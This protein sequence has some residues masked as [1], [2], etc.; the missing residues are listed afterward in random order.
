MSYVPAS[1]RRGPGLVGRGR[2]SPKAVQRWM[3]PWHMLGSPPSICLTCSVNKNAAGPTK[4]HLHRGLDIRDPAASDR[5]HIFPHATADKDACASVS[6]NNQR[7][8]SVRLLAWR[9]LPKKRRCVVSAITTKSAASNGDQRCLTAASLELILSKRDGRIVR[10][11]DR[12]AL[13]KSGG[14]SGSQLRLRDIQVRHVHTPAFGSHMR[15]GA[16][17]G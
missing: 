6:D 2:G 15:R 8:G 9:W 7:S 14:S 5:R 10:L 3:F 12:R 13:P 1:D 11:E 16:P 17:S 4:R